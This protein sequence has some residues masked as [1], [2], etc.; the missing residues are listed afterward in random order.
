MSWVKKNLKIN[1]WGGGGGGGTIIRDSR[2]VADKND[3]VKY[4]DIN[5]EVFSYFN[6]LFERTDQIDN[7]DHNTLLQSIIL[8]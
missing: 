3:L 6:S 5:N 7:L 2:V 4:N 1:N 8:P